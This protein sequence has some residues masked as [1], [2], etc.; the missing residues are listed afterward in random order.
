MR[1]KKKVFIALLTAMIAATATL[2]V[3]AAAP[4]DGK[5]DASSTPAAGNGAWEAW[6]E[7]WEQ[8]KN[9]WTIVSLSPGSDETKMNFSWYSK[10]PTAVL[11][12]SQNE[13]MSNLLQETQIQGETG[14]VE[15][16]NGIDT[17]YYVCQTT[18]ENLVPGTYYYQIDERDIESFTVRDSQNAFSFIFVGDP[19]IGSSNELK[20][21]DT[22][23][24][25]QA[26]SDAVRNDSFNWNNTLN[27]ALQK[28]PNA[29]FVVSAG[30]QIQTTKKKAP[31]QSVA[32]SE[33]EY[34]GYLLPD[35]LKSLPVATTVGNH[36]A[37]NPNYSYHFNVTNESELGSNGIVGGDYYYT[38]GDAL[39]IML[40]TQ[41]TNVAEH[42]KFMEQTIAENPDKKW[43]IVTL[44]QDI[45]GSGEH[46]NEPEITNL[47][48]TLV[49]Y[50]EEY[51]VDVV[52]T[53]HDHIYSRSQILQGGKKTVEYTDD[54]FE[55]QLE[56]DMDGGENPEGRYI[57]LANIKEDT[58][59]PDEQA[60]LSY[61]K[62]VMD[63]G[64]IED[65]NT[66]GQAVV[67]P[68]GILYMTANS[69]SGSKYYD[70]VPR[71]QSY[72]AARWQEDVP[73]YSVVDMTEDSFTITTYRTDNNEKIDDS[74]TILKTEEVEESS[75]VSY[76]TH[77]QNQGWQD[78]VKNGETSGSVDENLRIEA[79]KMNLDGI[80]ADGSIQYRTHVQNEGWQNFV[81]DDAISGTTGKNLRVEAMQIQLT[82]EIAKQY[83]IYYRTY[84]DGI[85]WLDWAAN[86]T[87]SGSIGMSKCITGLQ[88]QLV[89][90]GEQ[91]PGETERPSI[92]TPVLS[93]RAHV[94]N[95]G[96]M[97]WIQNGVVGTTGKSLRLEALNIK[98]D[99][100]LT[101]DIEYSV[102]VQNN[103][104][105]TVKKNGE[106]AGTTGANLRLEAV[107][108]NVT[109]EL[110]QNYNISYRVHV[111]NNGWTS[112]KKNGETAGT[113]GKSLRLEAM[114][115]KLE[116]K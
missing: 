49:P 38:Y 19:Q 105:Q 95:Q 72:I 88:V 94:Q 64:A 79:V 60:Y 43:R 111:Q 107:R 114:E 15:S 32:N 83:D 33:I 16:K 2:P 1:T 56:K 47:R 9:D 80:E 67:N 6:I 75:T 26:Q 37:D 104:W 18:V 51:D 23:A 20:G 73:T 27:Q 50:F 29:S 36:D 31:N 39:F 17:T 69:S 68:E 34:T 112:W 46:S 21:S 8:K 52:L 5:T 11:K 90:K 108:I 101:G 7:Q 91:A 66:D 59:D 71:M 82:G 78:Y 14:P 87:T 98:L 58:T 35:A 13:D 44:H 70:L 77:V 76:S 62:A 24:F 84:V 3:F 22:E 28:S 85:G 102:H 55:E 40:N 54:A 30:D 48:Y 99:S 81:E 25:Y 97:E 109:G 116:R 89:K 74:F 115:I 42:K 106:L 100:T 65:V 4:P 12:V 63:E 53:G 96:W 57:A 61:L 110:A 10:T 45:Y 93:Y 41:D 92:K 86:G 103:G 113:V